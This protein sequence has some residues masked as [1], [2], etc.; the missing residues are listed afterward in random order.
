[1]MTADYLQH[2]T[3][4]PSQTRSLRPAAA[5][6]EARIAGGSAAIQGLVSRLRELARSGA[7]VLLTGERGTGKTLFARALHQAS[8][9]REG[10]FVRLSGEVSDPEAMDHAFVAAQGGTLLVA[11]IEHLARDMQDKLLLLLA[12]SAGGVRLLASASEPLQGRLGADL[13]ALFADRTLGLPT[14]AERVEDIP[15]LA[16][17]FFEASAARLRRSGLRGISPEATAALERYSWPDNVRG[18]ERAIEQAMTFA[19][20]PYVTV[21]DLPEEVRPPLSATHPRVVS[22]LP[23]QGMDLRAAV[24]E[25][26]T[27]MILQALER[28]GWNKNRAAGLLG[29][30]RTTLVE[31]IKRKR[32]APPAPLRVPSHDLGRQHPGTLEKEG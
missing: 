31:M 17:H 6:S 30:N 12:Q 15:A 26:E 13:L 8:P 14:L 27:R 20:G 24:E 9:R 2:E 10:P 32:L 5:P 22:T 25:F 3:T 21:A 7:P 29:L 11:A 23:A 1:M 28:T 18:L 19:E 4:P 16:R